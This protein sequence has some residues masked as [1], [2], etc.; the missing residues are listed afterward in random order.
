MNAAFIEGL[1]RAS[2]QMGELAAL[3]TRQSAL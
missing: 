1:A 2:V 3:R